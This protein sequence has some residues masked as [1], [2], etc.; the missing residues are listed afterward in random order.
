MADSSS[1]AVEYTDVIVVGARCAGSAA[2]MT[3]ARAGRRV[4][5][6]DSAQF[7]SDTLSTHLL[8]PGGLAELDALGVLDQ[9]EELGAP[10]LTS[11]FAAG[12][13]Y[14]VPSEFAPADGIDYAMCVRRTGLDAVLVGAARTAGAEVRER[15][16]VT[17]LVWEDDRCAGV[18]YRDRADTVVELRAPLVVGADGR[19]STVARLCG[20][21][22]PFL[23]TP[24]GR[25]CYYAYWREGSPSWRHIAAQWRAGRDLGTAFPCDDGL[26]LSLVQPPVSAE[27]A[28]GPGRAEQRYAE[29]IARIPGLAER[30]RDCE[31]VGRVRAATGIASYFRRSSGPGWALAGD[32]GHFKDPVTAQ[33]I[34]D[35]LRYGRLLAET[36]APLLDHPKALDLALTHWADRRLRECLPIYQW[37]NRLARAEDMHPLEIELYRTATRDRALAAAVTGIFSR[38]TEPGAV[39][40][41]RRAVGLAAGALRHTPTTAGAVLADVT[42]ELR[43]AAADWHEARTALRANRDHST[44]PRTPSPVDHPSRAGDEDV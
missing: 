33:G 2:A 19:R 23:H 16:R 20:A 31:R 13:G 38:T 24:S 36:A 34:R 21:I 41:P 15:C 27:P 30:L 37:T 18:R 12:A 44:S 26:V 28:L 11:A 39:F 10:R 14:R 29:A 1:T 35:A 6:L 17:E 32:A 42:R 9:V 8:W 7:P 43:E 40:T 5:V 25:E 4:I 3:M 22:E